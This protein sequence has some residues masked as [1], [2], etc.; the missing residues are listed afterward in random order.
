MYGFSLGLTLK[1]GGS[2]AGADPIVKYISREKGINLSKVLFITGLSISLLFIIVRAF[3]DTNKDAKTFEEFLKYTIASAEFIS[4]ISFMVIYAKITESMYSPTKR[5]EVSVASKKN[6]ELSNLLNK[7]N[8]HRGHTLI[9]AIGG[10]SREEIFG[11]K[12]VINIEEFDDISKIIESV[13]SNAMITAHWINRLYDLHDWTPITKY[14]LELKEKRH[15]ATKEIE[16]KEKNIKDKDLNR[17][18]NGD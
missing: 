6:L 4:T 15:N 2:T 13:D 18:N 12:M 5:I 7:S 11:L 17:K 14:D 10:Y 9:K 16:K 1:N 3:T 8:Y